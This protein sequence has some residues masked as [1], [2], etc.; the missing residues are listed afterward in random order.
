MITLLLLT[1]CSNEKT[2]PENHGILGTW[3]ESIGCEVYVMI[4]YEDGTYVNTFEEYLSDEE[5]DYIEYTF[6]EETGILGSEMFEY[7]AQVQ[8]DTESMT[9]S[10]AE[11]EETHTLY[12]DRQTAI[13]ND[14][15]YY[16]SD[17]FTD[18]IID[19][20]GFCIKDGILYAYRGKATE[21]TVPGTVK[22]IYHE[23][24]AGD[25]N[26]GV[27]LEKVTIPGTVKEIKSNAFAFTNADCIYVEE[28]L[29]IIGSYAFMDSYIEE[30][31][32]PSTLKDIGHSIL[33]TEEGLDETLI[34]V[35]RDSAIH[36]YFEKNMPYGQ[37]T[38]IVE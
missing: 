6:N 32:F 5:Q 23:A 8:F 12:R 18:T 31:H 38:L 36:T 3:Y 19:G 13:E 21:I 22:V 4:F 17:E 30:V 29:E 14:P 27:N 2:V 26:H 15:S 1:G 37:A 34:Y 33:E 10:I 7:P 25:Y 20:D 28:G 35:P 9:Y 11:Y 16:T 24:F